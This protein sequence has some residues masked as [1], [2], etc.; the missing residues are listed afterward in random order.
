MFSDTVKVW[1]A[2]HTTIDSC[3]NTSAICYQNIFQEEKG[4][5]SC[6]FSHSPEWGKLQINF[7]RC[8]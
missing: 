8:H 1:T 5:E 2:I 4:W 7:L 3:A 6:I